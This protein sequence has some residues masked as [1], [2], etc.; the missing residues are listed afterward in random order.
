[1]HGS[2]GRNA[3]V[4]FH[5]LNGV[6]SPLFF[7]EIPAAIATEEVARATDLASTFQNENPIEEH[8]RPLPRAAVRLRQP[9][10]A[11]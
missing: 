11:P 1:M 7:P 5:S 4:E 3:L 6:P 10:V 9:S 8:A 2:I